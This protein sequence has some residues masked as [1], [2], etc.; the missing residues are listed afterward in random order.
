MFRG[1]YPAK[2]DDKGRLKIPAEFR[3]LIEGQWGPEVFITSIGGQS[4]LLYPLLVWEELESRLLA[5]PSTHVN[6]RRFLERVNYFGQQ[7]KLDPQGRLLVPPILRES[8]EMAGEVVV[9][10]ALD[11]VVVWNRE[12][13]KTKLR[14]EPFTDSDL[15]TLTEVGV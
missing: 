14:E 5:L 13:F 10:G 15:Q 2:I 7:A 12:T 3:R 11:H 1:S 4:A 9:C 6:R 8:G